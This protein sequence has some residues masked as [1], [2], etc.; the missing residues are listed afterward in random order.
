MW[1][2]IAASFLTLLLAGFIYYG[3]KQK[4][5]VNPYQKERNKSEILISNEVLEILDEKNFKMENLGPIRVKGRAEP[6]EIVR[7]F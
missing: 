2:F 4:Q 5:R 1:F 3:L 7:L 6:I